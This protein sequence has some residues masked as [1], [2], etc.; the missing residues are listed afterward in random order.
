M[1]IRRWLKR[2]FKSPGGPRRKRPGNWPT[3]EEIAGLPP[4]HALRRENV[5]EVNASALAQK[6]YHELAAESVVGFDTESRPTFRKGEV[7]TGPHVAQFATAARAYVF[8]LNDPECRKAAAALI[9]LKGLKKVGFGLGDDLAR[10]RKKL[11]VEPRNVHDLETLFA[12]KG[13]G[14]GVGA[15]VG[16]ALLFKRRFLKSKKAGTS[17]WGRAVLDERQLLYAANDAYAAIRA[18]NGLKSL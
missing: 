2:L 14:R 13:F 12:E 5:A 3:K 18:Y 16:I 7:S 6:A 15:K 17:N 9:A 10:V 8:M 11:K 4:F 1:I